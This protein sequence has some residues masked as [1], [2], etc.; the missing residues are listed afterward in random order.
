[1]RKSAEFGNFIVD[2]QPKQYCYQYGDDIEDN[3]LIPGNEHLS[4]CNACVVA[5]ITGDDPNDI[6]I[7]LDEKG[8]SRRLESN[9]ID[10]LNEKGYKTSLMF[11]GIPKDNKNWDGYKGRKGKPEDFQKIRDAI[12]RENLVFVHIAGHYLLCRGYVYHPNKKY[13]YIF[14]D[15]AGDMKLRKKYRLPESGEGVIYT[16]NFLNKRKFYGGTYEVFI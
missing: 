14:N 13:S 11:Y 1:M 16:T 6:V 12:D 2:V 4:T 3:P 8:Q 7:E 5:C 15:S 9:L 10:L